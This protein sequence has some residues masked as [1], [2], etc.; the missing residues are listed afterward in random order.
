[1]YYTTTPVPTYS[2]NYDTDYRKHIGSYGLWCMHSS[3]LQVTGSRTTI[4][5]QTSLRLNRKSKI[6]N[7]Y[8]VLALLLLALAPA[9][10][11]PTPL[12]N[13]Y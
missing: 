10:G 7:S 9:C 3:L 5:L 13:N 8:V 6:E 11:P 2:Q 12:T 1:M 4:I